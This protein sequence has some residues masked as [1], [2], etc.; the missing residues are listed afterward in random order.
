MKFISRSEEFI[1][2]AVWRLKEEAYAVTI[3]EQIQKVTGKTWAFG[4]L[5]VM[6]NRLEKKGLLQSHLTDPLPKRG[7]RS[8]RIYTLSPEGIKALEEV[9]DVQTSVWT[10]IEN[11]SIKGRS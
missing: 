3:R 11:F 9:R 4:A 5:F 6:L 1:M 8:K 10:G 2:L 7:G